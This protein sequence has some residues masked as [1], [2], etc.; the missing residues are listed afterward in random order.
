MGISR[1]ED[2]EEEGCGGEDGGKVLDWQLFLRPRGLESEEA[3]GGTDG[4]GA[5]DL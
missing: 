3:C 2:D 5:S 4:D 1:G